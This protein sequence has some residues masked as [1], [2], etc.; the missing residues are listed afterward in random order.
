M[1][2]PL[3]TDSLRAR[4]KIGSQAKALAPLNRKSLGINVGQTLSS[5]NADFFT[6]SHG[7]GSVTQRIN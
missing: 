4:E 1:N 2:S 7:R 3:D 5:A 6:A